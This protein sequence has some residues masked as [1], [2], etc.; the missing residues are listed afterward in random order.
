MLIGSITGGTLVLDELELEDEVV[1]Q[2]VIVP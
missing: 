1:P 2:P